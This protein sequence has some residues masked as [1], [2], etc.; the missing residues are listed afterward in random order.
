MDEKTT[1]TL[2]PIC[3]NC[4][5][6]MTVDEMTATGKDLF[7]I[8]TSEEVEFNI[9]CPNCDE[10]FH[11]SGSYTPCYTTSLDEDDF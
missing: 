9:P 2:W 1:A 4:F 11:I 7:N 6:E 8:A 10:S 3:P 5:H